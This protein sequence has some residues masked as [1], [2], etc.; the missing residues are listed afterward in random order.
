M[1]KGAQKKKKE[2]ERGLFLLQRIQVFLYIFY[3]AMATLTSL[4]GSAT[5]RTANASATT[6]PE[7]RTARSVGKDTSGIQGQKGGFLYDI[8]SGLMNIKGHIR[9]RLWRSIF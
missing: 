5:P 4:P 9:P 3:S 7:E 1:W 2:R 8:R 6:T